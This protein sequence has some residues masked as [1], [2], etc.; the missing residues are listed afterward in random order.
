MPQTFSEN[1]H[2]QPDNLQAMINLDRI[3]MMRNALDVKGFSRWFYWNSERIHDDNPLQRIGYLP[4][5][6]A[7]PT[8]DAVVKKTMDIS[9]DIKN[10][11]NQEYIIVS[12]DLAIASRALRIQKE[13]QPLYNNLFICVASFHT[14][15]SM[16][17]A[18]GKYI[19]ESGIPRLLVDSG[20]LA[21]GS[22]KAVLNGK[23]CNHC[24]S[25][26]VISS[27]AFKCLHFKEFLKVYYEKQSDD[28]LCEDEIIEILSHGCENKDS[29][30]PGL[31]SLLLAYNTYFDETMSGQHGLTAKFAIIYVSLIDLYLL[32]ER[33]IRTCDLDLH[34]YAMCNIC[35]LLFAFNH[36]NYSRWLSLYY[37]KFLNM[38]ITDPG[39]RDEFLNG[40]LSIR[41]TSKNFARS[42]IDLT[43]EQTINANAANKLTGISSFRNSIDA[44]QKWAETHTIRMEIMSKFFD[45]IGITKLDDGT[46]TEYKSKNFKIKVKRFMTE[47]S[48]NINPFDTYI[49]KS[50]LFNLPSGKSASNETAQSLLSVIDQGRELLELFLQKCT[51]DEYYFHKPIKRTKVLTFSNEM[52]VKKNSDNKKLYE[53]KHE[54]NMLERIINLCISKAIDLGKMLQYPLTFAPPSLA[55]HDGTMFSKSEKGEFS[56]LLIS[57]ASFS[58]DVEPIFQIIFIDG[59]EFVSNL[60]NIPSKFGQLAELVLRQLCSS[61]ALEIHCFFDHS[62]NNSIRDVEFQRNEIYDNDENNVF[63]IKGPNQER[64]AN[65]GKHILNHKFRVKLVL[66]LL[67]YWKAGNDENTRKSLGDKRLFVSFG[68][69]CFLYCNSNPVDRIPMGKKLHG[70]QNDHLDMNTK[71]IMHINK[72]AAQANILIHVKNTDY[73]LVHL[74]FHMQF[75]H[76]IKN[77][78]IEIG[79]MKKLNFQRICVNNIF[80]SLSLPTIKAIPGWYTFCGSSYEPAFFG[81]GIKTTWKILQRDPKFITSF[82]NLGTSAFE[83]D[84]TDFEA[85]ESFTCRLYSTRSNENKVNKLRHEIFMKAMNGPGD[86]Y[87]QKIGNFRIIYII[88]NYLITSILLETKK[89][90]HFISISYFNVGHSITGINFKAMPPCES[91]LLNKIRRS[92]QVTQLI[93]QSQMNNLDVPSA[94]DGWLI[95]DDGKYGI[96][97]F[98]GLPY[99]D[100]ITITEEQESSDSEDIEEEQLHCNFDSD[101]EDNNDQSDTE[102][103]QD[104]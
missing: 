24:K 37:Q 47:I 59:F 21:E 61:D 27:L 54:L 26:H 8:S 23:H 97:Y 6:N 12:Y 74:I 88:L 64:P 62:E 93:K 90:N 79:D 51:E 25:L 22:L 2:T 1:R 55:Y 84:K 45:E 83:I 68:N 78:W 13:M 20:L 5:I 40:A 89:Q 101:D 10:E 100:Q 42:P 43:L 9:L 35:A 87:L 32:Y 36:Q 16:F 7:S 67:E 15:M 94:S 95:N 39:L 73:L 96:E 57:S 44:R 49:D 104:D 41:R 69:N 30:F 102:S 98:S 28:I 77:I 38:D 70:F 75:W 76:D 34:L 11:C 86:D 82:G 52:P 19:N 53:T 33:S 71:I 4:Q 56:N 65:F 91:V 17:K 18:V 14:E 72:T 63:I 3:W 60:Q 31:D 103:D 92:I 48:D 80:S 29:T 99:P 46:E 50:R 81:K 66:F 85:L 58:T